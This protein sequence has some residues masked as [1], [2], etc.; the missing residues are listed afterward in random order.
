MNKK[1]I[2]LSEKDYKV[3]EELAG[4]YG[5]SVDEL[6]RSLLARK[7]PRVQILLTENELKH[8]DTNAI[9]VGLSRSEYCY[10]CFMKAVEEKLYVNTT[11]LEIQRKDESGR[12]DKKLGV[13]FPVRVQYEEMMEYSETIGVNFSAFVRYFSLNVEL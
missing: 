12:R 9:R 6:G 11:A 5:V 10:R 13:N 1:N 2:K 3:V 8:I 7:Y 4:K